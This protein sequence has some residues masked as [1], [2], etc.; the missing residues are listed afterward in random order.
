M[1]CGGL[2]MAF[3]V[4]YIWIL[5]SQLMKVF[6]KYLAHLTLLEAVFHDEWALGFEKATL[7]HLLLSILRNYDVSSQSLF[8]LHVCLPAA[9]LSTTVV[10]ISPSETV[11]HNKPF[12]L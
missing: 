8:Q 9:I 10:M 2:R 6:G 12:L 7:A 4:L 11:S 3:L 5:G 1:E